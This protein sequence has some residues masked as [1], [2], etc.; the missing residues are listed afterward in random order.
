MD[1]KRNLNYFNSSDKWYYIGLPIGILGCILFVSALFYFYFIPYQLPIGM[2]L[3]VI[4][5]TIA[6]LPYSRCAKESEI[7]EIIQLISENYSKELSDQFS[8]EKELVKNMEPLTVGGYIYEENLPMRRGRSDRMCRTSQY[9]V[10]KIFCMKY[11]IVV[12]AKSFSLID[13]SENE[14]TDSYSF[15]DLDDVSV[16]DEYFVCKDQS[17]IKTSYFVVKKDG[18]D[19]LRLPVKHDVAIEKYCN[20]INEMIRKTK[21]T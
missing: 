21:N 19:I 12:S 3:T 4:G 1:H 8:F 2:L 7:D 6:F 11:G 20:L 18:N 15:T 17:K 9:S 14:Y 10:A 5:A 16:I 13:S